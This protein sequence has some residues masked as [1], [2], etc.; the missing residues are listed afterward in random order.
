MRASAMAAIAALALASLARAEPPRTA[1]P[2][3][4]RRVPQ[5]PPSLLAGCTGADLVT[6]YE[7]I[8]AA[9]EVGAPTYNSG[10]FDGCYRIYERTARE[11]ETALPPQCA[12]PTRAL[13][14]GRRRARGLATADARAWAMRDAFDGLLDVLER[15]VGR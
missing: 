1:L 2:P 13:V 3:V 14:E 7:R 10:D 6:I 5:H 15:A 4:V 9:I 12:G 11:I 8:G